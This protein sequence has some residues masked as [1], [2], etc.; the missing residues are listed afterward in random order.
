MRQSHPPVLDHPDNILE[1]KHV[2]KAL[3]I[4]QILSSSLRFI[5]LCNVEN[6]SYLMVTRVIM[7]IMSPRVDGRDGAKRDMD[8]TIP[9]EQISLA[10][11][12]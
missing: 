12:I 7:F 3:I 2:M 6:S 1:G 9:M 10:S 4:T 11:G 5:K 8:L